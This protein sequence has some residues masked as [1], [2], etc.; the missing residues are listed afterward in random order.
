MI[1][2]LTDPTKADHNRMR[3]QGIARLSWVRIA[4]QVTSALVQ[5]DRRIADE[6]RT[7]VI[8]LL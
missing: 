4:S 6:T 7:P 5:A 2:K 1:S 3:N 8:R